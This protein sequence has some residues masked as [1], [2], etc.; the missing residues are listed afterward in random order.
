MNL[1]LWRKMLVITIVK[2]QNILTQTPCMYVPLFWNPFCEDEPACRPQILKQRNSVKSFARL[3]NILLF[4][5]CAFKV[6]QNRECN[7]L[8]INLWW[9]SRLFLILFTKKAF[10]TIYCHVLIISRIDILLFLY[11]LL[12]LHLLFVNISDTFSQSSIVSNVFIKAEAG[13]L[14]VHS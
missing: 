10:A 14:P 5:M 12:L 7:L 1:C 6:N 11:Y 3:G 9:C 2:W 4:K 13:T 8:K